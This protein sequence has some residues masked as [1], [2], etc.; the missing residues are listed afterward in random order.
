[1]LKAWLRPRNGAA[2]F[3]SKIVVGWLVDAT[4]G[5]TLI[6]VVGVKLCPQSVSV[7][8]AM[9][10]KTKGSARSKI[11]SPVGTPAAIVKSRQDVSTSLSMEPFT[12]STRRLP[13]VFERD[14]P[15]DTTHDHQRLRFGDP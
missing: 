6:V 2:G 15:F 13:S 10:S 11:R 3:P 1:M 7:V 14:A 5:A 8:D 4:G 12:P 9:V